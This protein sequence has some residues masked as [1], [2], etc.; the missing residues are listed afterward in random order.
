MRYLMTFHIWPK[1][2]RLLTQFFSVYYSTYCSRV[3]WAGLVALFIQIFRTCVHPTPALLWSPNFRPLPKRGFRV[4]YS[5]QVRDLFKG[6]G[7][8]VCYIRPYLI[9]AYALW[10]LSANQQ[11]RCAVLDK[12]LHKGKE[13]TCIVFGSTIE[14]WIILVAKLVEWSVSRRDDSQFVFFEV[15]VMNSKRHCWWNAPTRVW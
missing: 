6:L 2:I 3:K 10:Q 15:L 8:E 7:L 12:G 14:Y 5:T 13:E 4:S 1:L 9:L 11:C